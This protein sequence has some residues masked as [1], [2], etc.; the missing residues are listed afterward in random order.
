[1][2]KGFA[3]ARSRLGDSMSS[4]KKGT[5]VKIQSSPD[6]KGDLVGAYLYRPKTAEERAEWSR[7]PASEGMTDA[8]ETKLPPRY[9]SRRSTPEEL[10]VVVKARANGSERSKG[11]ALVRDASGTEWFVPR[12]AL[13]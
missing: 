2:W 1:M 5:I 12:K 8:G 7:S 9:T 4:F 11:E 10:V 3:A 6:W 13:S